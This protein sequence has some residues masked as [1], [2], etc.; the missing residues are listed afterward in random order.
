MFIENNTVDLLDRL[1]VGW[2]AASARNPRLVMVRLP[3]TGLDGP[4]R[5]FLGFGTNMEALFGLTA[6]RGYPDLDV[7]ENDS[8]YH[9]DAAT[10]GTAAFATLAALRRRDRTGVGELIELAQS[11][12]MLNHIGEMLLDVAT[13]RP[14]SDLRIGQPPP[15]AGAAGRLPLPRRRARVRAVPGSVGAGGHDRWVAISVGNDDEWRGVARRDGRP[16]VGSRRAVRNRR[17][18]HDASRRDR[19]GHQRGGRSASAIAT[20]AERCQAHGVPAAP[21]LTE[22]EQR[23]D[24]H[25]R[26]R[27]MLRTN[28]GPTSAPTSSRATPGTGTVRRSRGGRSGRW[29]RT[30]SDVYRGLLGVDDAT[31]DALVAEGHITDGFHG[32]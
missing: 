29:A 31:W 11:E 5:H 25:L 3:S 1:G 24:P 12:N 10:G 19:R 4:Y 15:L 9:M 2:E 13:R 21:V 6:I 18:R 23:A 20:P 22:S 26:A 14:T 30:T 28:H 7:G 16:G 8:V 32:V 17:G 27:G